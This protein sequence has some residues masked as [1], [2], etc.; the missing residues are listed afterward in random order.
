MVDLVC[1]PDLG[2]ALFCPAV[3]TGGAPVNWDWKFITQLYEQK[4]LTEASLMVR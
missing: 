3:V 2:A 1:M 4:F